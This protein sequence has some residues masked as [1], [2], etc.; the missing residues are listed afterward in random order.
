MKNVLIILTDQQR[1]ELLGEML[2]AEPKFP[3]QIT[4]A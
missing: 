3:T 4:P 1:Q 2:A